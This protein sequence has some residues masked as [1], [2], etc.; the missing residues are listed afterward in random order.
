MVAE[1]FECSRRAS[2][3]MKEKGVTVSGEEKPHIASPDVYVYDEK[4]EI[5]TY[6]HGLLDD[7]VQ[8]TGYPRRRFQ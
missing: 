7:A 6:Y 4:Q 5:R 1:R 8:A 2:D 3:E